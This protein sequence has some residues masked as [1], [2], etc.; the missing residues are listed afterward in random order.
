MLGIETRIAT[1]PGQK[2]LGKILSQAILGHADMTISMRFVLLFLVSLPLLLPQTPSPPPPGQPPPLMQQ[3]IEKQRASI[4]KQAD[5]VHGFK[6]SPSHSF[7][8]VPWPPPPPLPESR[9]IALAQPADCDPIPQTQL[10]PMIDSAARKERLQPSLLHR[11]MEQESAFKPCAESPKGAMGLMQLMPAT[12]SALAVADPWNPLQNI[13][14]GAHYLRQLLDRYGGD[15][16]LAL[17]AYN[18]GPARVDSEGKVP[19]IPETQ[20]YVNSILSRLQTQ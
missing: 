12:A 5:A 20:N 16:K 6:D 13:A 3:A 7:F 11:V 18:A 8:A 9:D 4:R 10:Q 15:L 19:P 1:P 2:I 17:S 14:G